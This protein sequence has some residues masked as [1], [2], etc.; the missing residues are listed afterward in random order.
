MTLIEELKSNESVLRKL[1]EEKAKFMGQFEQLKNDLDAK[2]K[3]DNLEEAAKLLVENN[4][5]LAEITKKG[6]VLLAKINEAIEKA[7][8]AVE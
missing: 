5:K 7:K 8:N 2:I 1:Q 4:E 6:D 3:I